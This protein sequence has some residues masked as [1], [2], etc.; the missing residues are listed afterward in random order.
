[1]YEYNNNNI[2]ILFFN[3][4]H[5]PFLLHSIKEAILD[6][7]YCEHTLSFKTAIY[8]IPRVGWNYVSHTMDRLNNFFDLQCSIRN[9]V[10]YCQGTTW[11]AFPVTACMRTMCQAILSEVFV[12]IWFIVCVYCFNQSPAPLVLHNPDMSAMLTRLQTC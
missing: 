6:E 3:E 7:S 4:I 11:C 10:K 8:S 2:Y 1:M 5:F 9:G 12:P